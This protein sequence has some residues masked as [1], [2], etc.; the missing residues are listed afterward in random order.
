MP[1]Y[2][3]QC[4][5]LNIKIFQWPNGSYSIF[6][7]KPT[8]RP[9]TLSTTGT[10]YGMFYSIDKAVKEAQRKFNVHQEKKGN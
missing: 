5:S 3:G 10:L 9:S 2:T 1:E 8:K 7:R 6:M 4:T